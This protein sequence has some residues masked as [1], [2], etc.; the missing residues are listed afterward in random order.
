MLMLVFAILLESMVFF[1]IHLIILFII[2]PSDNHQSDTLFKIK[3]IFHSSFHYLVGNSHNKCN[4][5]T[6]ETLIQPVLMCLVTYKNAIIPQSLL[7]KFKD[8]IKQKDVVTSK[9]K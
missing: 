5:D 4:T 8:K 3:G 6:Q 9:W 7:K 1:N 2:Q